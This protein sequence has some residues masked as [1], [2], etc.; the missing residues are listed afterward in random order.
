MS[1]A[2]ERQAVVEEARTWLKTPYRHMGRVKGAGT[3]CGMLLLCVFKNC[4]LVQ[5]VQV[6]FYPLDIACHSDRTDYL[7]WIKRYSQQVEREPKPGDVI[8]YKFPG[9]KV[10]HHAAICIDDEY[11]IHSY[12]KQGVILSHR[13]QYDK[14]RHGVFSFWG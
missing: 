3:D 2:T 14:F 1:E 11:I 6:P 8:L 7:D 9:S 10:P 13:R 4:R 5:D 12:V